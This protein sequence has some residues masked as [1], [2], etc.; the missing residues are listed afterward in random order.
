MPEQQPHFWAKLGAVTAF[1][2][3]LAGLGALIVQFAD[4]PSPTTTEPTMSRPSAVPVREVPRSLVSG[5]YAGTVFNQTFNQTGALRLILEESEGKVTGKITITGGLG[6]SG[7][8]EGQFAE[9]RVTFI[10]TEG[11]TGTLITWEGVFDGDRLSG[12]YVVSLPLALKMQRPDLPD[13]EG[14]WE[15]RK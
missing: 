4:P 7:S 8:V 3:A 1:V 6:G 15:V 11:S 13:E 12:T 9:D 14:T 10:S 5:A 2:S